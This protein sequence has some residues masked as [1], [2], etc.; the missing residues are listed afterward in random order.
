MLDFPIKYQRIH[1]IL[2]LLTFTGIFLEGVEQILVI[3]KSN[4]IVEGYLISII[5]IVSLSKS[6]ALLLI[7]KD[8]V[9]RG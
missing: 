4:S 5:Q 3:S 1:Q 8:Q 7:R 2:S 6:N 9:Q